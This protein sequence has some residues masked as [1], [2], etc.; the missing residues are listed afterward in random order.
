[1]TTLT[2]N[3]NKKELHT[4]LFIYCMNADFIEKS[5]ELALIKNKI[6]DATYVK[7]HTEYE[8]DNDFESIQ[9]I[10]SAFSEHK[11][12]KEQMLTIFNEI[13]LL[14]LSDGSY[15]IL[16]RNLMLGLK[17]LLL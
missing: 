1:M 14:F 8:K 3:W 2:T 13:K 6:D 17:R 10:Q 15:N 7:M 5:D 9:K 11:Y 4:Y 16:E 12:S